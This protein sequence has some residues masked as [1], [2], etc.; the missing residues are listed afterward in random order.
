VRSAADAARCD[1]ALLHRFHFEMIAR[2]GIFFLPG[3][4]G[5][6]SAAHTP[7]DIRGLVGAA[8]RFSAMLGRGGG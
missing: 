5:A 8:E 4:L 6:V 1:T 2:D 3:K 7:S